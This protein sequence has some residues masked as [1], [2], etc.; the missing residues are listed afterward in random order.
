M[1]AGGNTFTVPAMLFKGKLREDTADYRLSCSVCCLDLVE[2]DGSVER[3]SRR[4]RKSNWTAKRSP[5]SD[6]D[7]PDASC[8]SQRQRRADYQVIEATWVRIESAKG[9]RAKGEQF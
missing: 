3:S 9:R 8:W 6:R 4:S 1:R 7:T 2:V 5:L